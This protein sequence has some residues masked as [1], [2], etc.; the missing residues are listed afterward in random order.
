MP[1]S[2]A[3]AARLRPA[4][5]GRCGRRAA[6]WHALALLRSPFI[7][8]RLAQPLRVSSAGRPCPGRAGRHLP[9]LP[10]SAALGA[11][12]HPRARRHELA[13]ATRLIPPRRLMSCSPAP[14]SQP[15]YVDPYLTSAHHVVPSH[16]HGAAS[17]SSTSRQANERE[18]T[19]YTG[20]NDSFNSVE[21]NQ[22]SDIEVIFP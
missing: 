20:W 19:M 18:D 22:N 1:S 3:L 15:L 14:R 6:D 5:S 4:F 2:P 17:S 10:T 11:I 8:P 7:G 21:F 12:R 16:S 13:D 9:P